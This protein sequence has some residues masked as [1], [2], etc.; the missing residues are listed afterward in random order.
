MGTANISIRKQT[1]KGAP[2]KDGFIHDNIKWKHLNGNSLPLGNLL[3]SFHIEM[4]KDL[5]NKNGN[6]IY[7]TFLKK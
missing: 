2:K 4:I 3:K 6:R 1:L 7:P 5:M